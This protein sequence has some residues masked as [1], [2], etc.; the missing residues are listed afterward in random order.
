MSVLRTVSGFT[1]TVYTLFQNGC[2]TVFQY[3]FV[4]F[5]TSPCCLVVKLK[6]QKNI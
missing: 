3:P 4:C 1:G 5:E 2:Y 6:I